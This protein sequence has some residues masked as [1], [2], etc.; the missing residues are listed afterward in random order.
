MQ[1]LGV[2][3]QRC[4]WPI[5]IV[6]C[7]AAGGVIWRRRFPVPWRK[8]TGFAVVVAAGTLL[9]GYP[10]LLFGFD[11]ISY[12]NDD[13]SSYVL[14]ATGFLKHAYLDSVDPRLILEG[15]ELALSR[16]LQIVLSGERHGVELILAWAM[17]LT[18]LTGYQV[19][20]PV[21]VAL[22]MAL[23]CSAGA[24]VVRSRNTRFAGLITCACVAGSSLVT[25]GT[26]YQLIAQVAGLSMLAC[27][28]CMLLEP[29]RN[30]PWRVRTKRAI[31]SGVLCAA[32]GVTYPE[33][34]P[35]LILGFG[36]MHARALWRREE[37]IGALASIAGVLVAVCLLLWNK[38]T[39]CIPTFLL[40]QLKH[41]THTSSAAHMLFPY[42]LVPSGLASFWGFLP[43][44]R[45]MSHPM[46]DIAIAGS[47]ILLVLAVS[48]VIWLAWQGEPG[49]AVSFVMFALGIRL[50]WL[51]S[52]FGMYK[53]A[54][55]IQ[56]FLLGSLVLA[57]ARL[58]EKT[59]LSP[60]MRRVVCVL[61][62]AILALIGLPAE[63]YY[64]HISAADQT[65]GGFTE[66]PGASSRHLISHLQ[67]LSQA[68]LGALVVSDTA[69]VGLAK[70]EAVYFSPNRQDYPSGEFVWGNFHP[71]IGWYADATRPGYLAGW[72][73]TF[74]HCR[75]MQ[76]PV[77]FDM[78]SGRT[79]LFIRSLDRVGG[80]TGYSVLSTGSL[81]SV[82]NRRQAIGSPESIVSLIDLRSAHDH[83]IEINS[84]LGGNYYYSSGSE[85]RTALY[86][87]EPD[88]FYPGRSMSALGRYILFEILQPSR[89]VRVEMDYTASL[90]GDGRNVIPPM[91]VI[92]EQPLRF[93]ALGRGSTRI[94]SPPLEPQAIDGRYYVAIDMGVEGQTFSP[95][96]EGLL[97]WFGTSISLDPR[98]I[99]G[100]VRDISAIGDDQYNQLA[101]PASV[102]R[103]PQGLAD[104]NLEY[105]GIYEDGWVGKESFLKLGRR[106]NGSELVV[107]L[108]VPELEKKAS[109]LRIL[110]DGN[111]VVCA[112]LHTGE[113]EIRT[114]LEHGPARQ[115]IDL[116][117]DSE[118]PLPG[119]DRRLVS[120]RLE[121]VGFSGN[122]R[123][124]DIAHGPVGMAGKRDPLGLM[125]P[126]SSISKFP[127][128][129]RRETLCTTLAINGGINRMSLQ[130]EG[131]LTR[132]GIRVS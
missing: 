73:A 2:P 122:G 29:N 49:A 128:T 112:A 23:I 95:Q 1:S 45:P 90:Q 69:N 62:I 84:E 65:S 12:A 100:F 22:H 103:F 46:I 43:V 8:L 72:M 115:Q 57:W 5:A 118:T 27:A 79:N 87:L 20:M 119:S 66:L 125:L 16:W 81:L 120:A 35:F 124:T 113:N 106:A 83:L 55:Y 82:V 116:R 50:A 104:K 74:K 91:S 61:P 59:C 54:M 34:L 86:Q 108:M 85:H 42:Y 47:A 21:I 67:L 102:A 58:Q 89:G 98:Q 109:S 36:L 94:F 48:G 14:A 10:L 105:G 51:L 4:G 126:D 129:S 26:I 33:V 15:R 97:R 96:R 38:F 6:C 13:M 37:T 75:A 28:A 30:H 76:R 131:G 63:H 53:L 88:Y 60:A 92:G 121:F 117:F 123:A 64:V 68:R 71:R 31:L 130:C 25:L 17:S 70:A 80:D 40:L 52:D 127:A 18:R 41:G 11:W 93:R 56:P 9:V 78:H 101:A 44:A 32:T 99:T 107:R 114:I 39:D 24:L 77:R 3:I 110:V 111:P 19:F 7:V 132:L